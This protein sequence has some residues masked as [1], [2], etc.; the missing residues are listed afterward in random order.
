MFLV[1]G[2]GWFLLALAVAVAVNDVLAWWSD[3]NLHL[4]TLGEL[5]GK[6]APGSLAE[7]Q[8]SVQRFGNPSLWQILARP[9]LTVPA[10][11]LFLG[12]GLLLVWAG[13]RTADRPDPGTIMSTRPRRRRRRAGLR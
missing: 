9:V 12:L 3:S 13:T 2:L 11:P 6:L 7:T 5:W 10:I 4:L 8:R 1:R